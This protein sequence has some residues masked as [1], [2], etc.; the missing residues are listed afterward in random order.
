MRAR[1][2]KRPESLLFPDSTPPGLNHVV[3]TGKVRGE[4][5]QAEGAD[6]DPVLVAE[7]EF[8]VA[9]PR[10]PKRLRTYARYLVEVPEGVGEEDLESLRLARPLLV[11]GQ[12]TK[13]L[14]LHG[15]VRQQGTILASLLKVGPAPE[16]AR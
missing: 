12:L 7:I 1:D 4:P 6:G 16:G 15:C 9:D 10:D 11:A 14:A 3:L 13:R 8:P 5:R 2:A